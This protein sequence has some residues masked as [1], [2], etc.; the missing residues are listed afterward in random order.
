MR[1]SKALRCR[2]PIQPRGLRKVLRHAL[3]LVAEQAQVERR[4]SIALRCRQ[5]KQPTPRGALA[6]GV[7]RRATTAS[8]SSV[9]LCGGIEVA[10]P[11]AMPTAPFSSSIGI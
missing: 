5:P 10:M 6:P 9:G 1:G 8:Q 11:T 2:Q 4:G 7:R 3:A